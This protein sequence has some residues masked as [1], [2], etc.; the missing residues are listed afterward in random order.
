[1][2]APDAVQ[3][4]LDRE[5]LRDLVARYALTVDDHDLVGL[6]AMFHPEAVFDRDGVVAHGWPEIAAVLG[7][8][9][10]GFRR[11]LHTPHAAVVE[12][13][14]PDEAVGA[15]SGHAELVTR[16]GVLLAA[17]RYADAFVRHEGRWVFSRREV[18]FLYAASAVEYAAT[19]PHEDRVR[20][21]GEPARESYIRPNDTQGY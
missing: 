9:M 1:M 14:G 4:L 11:M 16:S 10:R 8:S 20:F 19:L 18:R 5:Q 21:P 2:V 3:Q 15:S 7:A 6:E 13:T 12:L 17:Y